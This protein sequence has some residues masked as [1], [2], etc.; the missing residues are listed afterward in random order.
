MKKTNEEP[1]TKDVD[2]K[3]AKADATHLDGDRAK[4]VALRTAIKAGLADDFVMS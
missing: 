1:E 2:A 4:R 3:D